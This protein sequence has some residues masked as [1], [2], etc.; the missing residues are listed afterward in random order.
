MLIYENIREYIQMLWKTIISFKKALFTISSH[1]HHK[2]YLREI[3]I[4]EK[5]D[6]DCRMETN[7]AKFT[8]QQQD[9]YTKQKV[10]MR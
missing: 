9:G 7:I 1:F 2:N 4:N 5:R 8:T 3:L 6:N 10:E